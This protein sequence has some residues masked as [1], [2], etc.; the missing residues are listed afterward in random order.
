[1]RGYGAQVQGSPPK[2]RPM[3]KP[4]APAATGSGGL[5]IC[6]VM[7]CTGSMQPWIEA[8]KQTIKEMIRALPAEEKHKRVAFVGYRDFGDGP[9]ETIG[10]TEHV[11][12][13]VRFIDGQRAFG[14]GDIAEDVAGGL[15]EALTQTWV[16]QTR[17]LVLIADAPCHGAKYQPSANASDDYRRGD[18]TGLS[19]TRLL[20]MC[21]LS[22]IDFT[23][24]Q[25]T[26]ETHK[27]QEELRKIYESAAGSQNINKFELRDL[28]QI[29]QEAGGMA[30]M[31][32][33]RA[34]HVNQMLSAAITPTIQASYQNQQTGYQAYAPSVVA[35]YRTMQE[36]QQ[37]PPPT[38]AALSPSLS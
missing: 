10:F 36:P 16:S 19:M 23:F 35:S 20:Q 11:E 2:S 4:P 33:G 26:S 38:G 30:A 13:V 31:G 15:A 14:G 5:D 37:E 22:G 28:R 9:A 12:D 27:M 34:V 24:V 17:T 18:P 6:F 3:P 7:D 1:M 8:S 25:L 29:I 21:R 32:D